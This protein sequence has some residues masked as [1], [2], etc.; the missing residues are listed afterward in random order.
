MA[1][2]G[3]R[4]AQEAAQKFAHR[5]AGDLARCGLNIVSGYAAGIDTCA[6]AGALQQQ[7]TTT[8]VL[9]SGIYDFRPKRELVKLP[10]R[11][12]V[13]AV[14]QFHPSEHWSAR[15]AMKRNGL[16]CALSRAV[17]VVEA[18]ERVDAQGRM[19]GTYDA[20]LTVLRMHVPLFVLDPVC[21]PEGAKGNDDLIGKGDIAVKAQGAADDICKHLEGGD[22]GHDG[23]VPQARQ[24]PLF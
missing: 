16:V 4:H 10:H 24:R 9:S 22:A 13:L 18:G 5:L 17:V 1:I 20:G 6:H 11:R 19:S 15:N 3:S 12:A 23:H 8:A 7:G 14:S 2:V 21:L